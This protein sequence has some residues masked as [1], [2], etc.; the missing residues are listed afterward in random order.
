MKKEKP[1]LFRTQMVK[2]ILAGKKTETRRLV[3]TEKPKYSSGDILWVRE[4]YCEPPY[5]YVSTNIG[6]GIIHSPKIVYRAST[7]KDYTGIWKSSLF[8]PKVYARIFL[9]VESVTRQ[10]LLDIT[11]SGSK[12]EGF[13]SR[14]KFLR[15]WD[16]INGKGSAE[17][18]PD[19]W[20]I[21]FH[22]V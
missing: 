5:E 11:E 1:I 15:Y 18:N 13:S 22:F 17:S 14:L 3:Q 12:R 10:K 21:K 6:S 2:A 16:E 9:E 19:V 7:E 20:V 8:M 4:T